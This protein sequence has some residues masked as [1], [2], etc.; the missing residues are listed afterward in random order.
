MI[1]GLCSPV[2][3]FGRQVLSQIQ[4]YDN[5]I[6]PVVDSLKFLTSLS[7]D[8]LA[9]CIME[10]LANPDRERMKH[11]DTNISLWLQSTS[12]R[13]CFHEENSCCHLKRWFQSVCTGKMVG[14]C[15]FCSSSRYEE[16]HR[17]SDDNGK[18]GCDHYVKQTENKHQELNG[19]RASWSR[20]CDGAITMDKEFFGSSRIQESKN[21]AILRQYKCNV[22]GKEW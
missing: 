16:S 5:F 14:R 17:R 18:R 4:K 3:W 7:Y 15:I 13:R 6:G 22:I 1:T 8:M 10:A 11:D 20:W 19:S 12:T 9:Y 21:S 2:L